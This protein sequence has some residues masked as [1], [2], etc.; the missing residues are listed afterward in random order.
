MSEH[1][2]TICTEE[3]TVVETLL[4]QLDQEQCWLS[5]AIDNFSIPDSA[6]AEAAVSY[7]FQTTG[8]QVRA[9]LAIHSGIALDLNNEDTLS[10]AN[11]A[12]LLHNASLIHDDVQDNDA[13]RRNRPAV[14][15]KFGT[16]VAICSGDLLISAAYRA[17]CKVTQPKLLPE[18]L[19]LVHNRTSHAIL[20][21]CA[22][23]GTH[24]NVRN[25]INHYTLLSKAKSGAL[26]S[27]PIEMTFLI[28][29]QHQF[30]SLAREACENFAV[31][32][33]IA[34][35][36]Q[37][38]AVD[39]HNSSVNPTQHP[40]AN[41][42]FIMSQIAIKGTTPSKTHVQK[43]ILLAQE[44]LSDC[45]RKASLLPKNSGAYLI[46]LAQQ[47]EINFQTICNKALL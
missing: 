10:I 21:Q 47:L 15:S 3:Q 36:V 18:L 44:Q 22:D 35:D 43:S 2:H 17:L 28:A 38:L 1:T 24:A 26:F 27:L 11:C 29:G 40:C 31:A 20:G 33:Q 41:I 14:W 25:P 45:V 4:S 46:R 6:N 19:N 7:H 5:K 39:M 9:R 8:S 42:V 12:E 16:N 37:D 32:Y 30:M 13:V 23:L 34:D